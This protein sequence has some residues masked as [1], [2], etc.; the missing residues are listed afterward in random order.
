MD[1]EGSPSIEMRHVSYTSTSE[2]V[3]NSSEPST[4]KL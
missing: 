2:T 4:Q 1:M 3:S